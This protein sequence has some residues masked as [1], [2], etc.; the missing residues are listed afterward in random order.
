MWSLVWAFSV[1]TQQFLGVIAQPTVI[2][3]TEAFT[4][5]LDPTYHVATN[6]T[7]HAGPN[8]GT[9]DFGLLLLT[10]NK[11]LDEHLMLGDLQLRVKDDLAAAWTDLSTHWKR[12]PV[13]QVPNSAYGNAPSNGALL[14]TDVTASLHTNLPVKVTRSWASQGDWLSLSFNVSNTDLKRSLILGGVGIPIPINN[15]WVHETRAESQKIWTGYL[16]SDAA[17]S[18][19]SGYVVTNRLNG[20]GPTLLTVP[21]DQSEWDLCELAEHLLLDVEHNFCPLSTTGAVAIE[22][23]YK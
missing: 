10:A 9:S 22:L 23:R 6:L 17:V 16:T 11:T 2:F 13:Q 15:R 7:S 8:A 18:L 1:V 4:L 20:Q 14:S 12:E 21:G 3:R 5:I 19:D